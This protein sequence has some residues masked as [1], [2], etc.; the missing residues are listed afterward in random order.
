MGYETEGQPK[1]ITFIA[2]TYQEDKLLKIGYAY[3]QAT[4]KRK[5]PENY[6]K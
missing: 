3:E 5:T 2:K 4:Q 1:N 6:K